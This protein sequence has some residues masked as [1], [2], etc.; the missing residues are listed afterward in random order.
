MY[1]Q[2]LVRRPP[3]HRPAPRLAVCLPL[4]IACLVAGP[5]A[6]ASAA[7]AGGKQG[8]TPPA[9]EVVL[10]HA[11]NLGEALALQARAAVYDHVTRTQIEQDGPADFTVVIGPL[12]GFKAARAVLTAQRAA[13]PEAKVHKDGGSTA[14]PLAV[15]PPV[16]PPATLAPAPAPDLATVPSLGTTEQPP[17][18]VQPNDSLW[19]LAQRFYGDPM[20][21]TAIAGANN[22]SHPDVIQV[23]QVLLIPPA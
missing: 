1:I 12:P 7:P 8:F 20:R 18:T 9:T 23:S 14:P 21:W 16:M 2:K 15:L 5:A 22:L 13:F 17:Y 3:L 19:S 10:G 4:A 11:R 6:A